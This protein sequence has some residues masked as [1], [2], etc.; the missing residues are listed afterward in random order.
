MAGSDFFLGSLT[1]EELYYRF[2]GGFIE[3]EENERFVRIP[4]FGLPVPTDVSNSALPID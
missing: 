2:G 4:S 1:N 3:R